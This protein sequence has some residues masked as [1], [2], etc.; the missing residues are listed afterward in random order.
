MD[1]EGAQFRR[2]LPRL[3]GTETERH[4]RHIERCG[5]G[6]HDQTIVR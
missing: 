2:Q 6:R 5:G 1:I 3:C 4:D